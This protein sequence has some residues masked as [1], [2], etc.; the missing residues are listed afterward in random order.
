MTLPK[1]F[2][3]GERLLANDLN[4]NN[5]YLNNK[6]LSLEQGYRYA[7][8]RYFFSDGQF[9][10]A[11][12]LGTG[13]IGLA[14]IR[15]RV[16]GAGGGVVALAAA[17]TGRASITGGGGGGGYAE[18]FITDIAGLNAFVTV[19]RGAGV[20]GGTGGQSA[21]GS[22]TA[23]GGFVGINVEDLA[24]SNLRYGGDGGQ[25]SGGDFNLR[26]SA[27][28]FG[29][30]LRPGQGNE[31]TSGQGGSSF[32]GGSQ[33]SRQDTGGLIADAPVNP[34]Q[35]ATGSVSNGL[36]AAGGSATSAIAGANGIV[37]VDCFV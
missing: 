36:G 24:Q 26:G 1:I 15:V 13:P 21:F 33:R 37:I 28:T 2:T 32:F 14:A 6:V 20:A 27:G 29:I 5:T 16:V 25:A 10:K 12:P 30:I 18:S 35:G 11:D 7:G 31:V 17:S 3:A 23:N 22:I 4:S 9:E 34:G 19:T 8:T